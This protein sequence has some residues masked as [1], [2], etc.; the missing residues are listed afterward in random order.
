VSPGLRDHVLA[1]RIAAAPIMR[2][3]GDVR[4]LPPT[5]GALA[6]DDL[7]HALRAVAQTIYHPAC[8]CPWAE[9]RSP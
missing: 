1:R 9:T 7:A 4:E 6:G 8:T 5:A 3:F 2:A